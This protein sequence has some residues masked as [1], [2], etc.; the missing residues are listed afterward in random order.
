[1]P[2]APPAVRKACDE[3]AAGKLARTP[4]SVRTLAGNDQTATHALA[5]FERRIAAQLGQAEFLLGKGASRKPRRSSS[6]SQASWRSAKT[7][8]AAS[9]ACAS[10]WTRKR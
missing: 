6:R 2:G 3:F 10:N 9:P 4:A 8:H 7:W 5:A 1:L